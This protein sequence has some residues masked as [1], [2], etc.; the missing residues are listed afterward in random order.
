MNLSKSVSG[1][2]NDAFFFP[3]DI[4]PSRKAKRS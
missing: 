1:L 3:D 2:G 4:V